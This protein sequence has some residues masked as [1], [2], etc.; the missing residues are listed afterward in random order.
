MCLAVPGQLVQW[1][2][3][4]SVFARA[5]VEFAGVR[6]ECQMACVPDAEIGDF[7]VVH[8]GIAISRVD[9]D[10]AAQALAEWNLMKDTVPPP[11]LPED[12]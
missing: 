6:R 11:E 4:D 3:R 1:I 9:Q 12:S 7:V 8:A 2:Q 5:V 10:Q